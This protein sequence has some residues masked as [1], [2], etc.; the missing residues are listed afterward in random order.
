MALA[1]VVLGGEK[2]GHF[3]I[4]INEQYRLCFRWEDGHANDVEVT[5]YHK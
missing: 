5:D 1:S 4:R 2:A 3:S